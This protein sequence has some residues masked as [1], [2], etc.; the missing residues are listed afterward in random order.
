MDLLEL[1][2]YPAEDDQ[3]TLASLAKPI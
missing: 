2:G 1:A 3:V